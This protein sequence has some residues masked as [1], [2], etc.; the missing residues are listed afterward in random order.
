MIDLPGPEESV[1]TPQSSPQK[2]VLTTPTPLLKADLLEFLQHFASDTYR[3]KGFCQLQ[4]GGTTKWYY[5]DSVKGIFSSTL[6]DRQQEHDKTEIIVI[7]RAGD[8]LGALIQE[9]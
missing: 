5:L 2:L 4:E 7:L 9:A 1:N 8:P 3:I 6:G